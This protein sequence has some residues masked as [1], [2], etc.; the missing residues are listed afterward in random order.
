MAGLTECWLTS[1]QDQAP[2]PPAR[3]LVRPSPPGHSGPR[4]THG[5]LAARHTSQ[6]LPANR[7][8]ERRRDGKEFDDVAFIETG[9]WVSIEKEGQIHDDIPLDFFGSF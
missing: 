2:P 6:G 4:R 7:H 8:A 5:P 1:G 3:L 9:R